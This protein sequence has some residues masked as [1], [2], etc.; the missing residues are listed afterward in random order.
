[1]S[2]KQF[3]SFDQYVD[4][5]DIEPFVLPISD[6]ETLTFPIPSGTALLRFTEAYRAGDTIAVLWAL[7]GD[8]WPRLEELL[9]DKPFTVMNKIMNDLVTHFKLV[10]NVEMELR[11]PGGG[12]IL[13]SN[14]EKIAQ[15]QRAGFTLVG[16]SQPR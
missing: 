11:G 15:L 5:A 4:E 16:E 9:S 7:C 12:K 8:Q 13:E 10:P 1:M 3:K 2:D 14:P 6:D